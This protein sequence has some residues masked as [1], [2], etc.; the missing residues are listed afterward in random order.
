MATTDT[1]KPV[2]AGENSVELVQIPS[3]HID[4]AWAEG[5]QK[6][7]LGLLRGEALQECSPEQLKFM[8]AREDL[9][10]LGAMKKDETFIGWAAVRF[11]QYPMF[12]ALHVYSIYA[13][14]VAIPE[15]FS[16]LQEYAKRAGASAIEGQAD[17][18]VAR[19]W[20]SR[21]GFQMGARLV[22]KFL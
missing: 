21:F 22:R 18:A 2:E 10:L 19:L 6:L 17:D 3:S 9:I 15:V 20:E 16:L 1:T 7:C 12:R 8:L 14:R 5:A 11:T 4:R 13:P